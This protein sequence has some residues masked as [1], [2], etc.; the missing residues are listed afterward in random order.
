MATVFL[1]ASNCLAASDEPATL[2]FPNE[3]SNLLRDE[4]SGTRRSHM[5]LMPFDRRKDSLLLGN[6]KP[7]S[8]MVNMYEV[9]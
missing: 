3:D 1:T 9:V 7:P 6:D 5:A 8:D 4:S 2:T